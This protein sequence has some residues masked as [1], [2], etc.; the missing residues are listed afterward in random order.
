MNVYENAKGVV[1]RSTDRSGGVLGSV[2]PSLSIPPSIH[3]SLSLSLILTLPAA[4]IPTSSAT[5]RKVFGSLTSHRPASS[6]TSVQDND[7][8][9]KLLFVSPNPP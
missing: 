4:P 5:N 3:P 1:D 8:D 6:L 2:T 9:E 7:A